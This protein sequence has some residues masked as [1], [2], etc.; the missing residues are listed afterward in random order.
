M[1]KG[2]DQN[3]IAPFQTADFSMK[4][5]IL[6]RK[7]R[8]IDA[9]LFTAIPVIGMLLSIYHN[10][11]THIDLYSVFMYIVPVFVLALHVF[12][13][14]DWAD[15]TRDRNDKL[16]KPHPFYSPGISKKVIIILVMVTGLVSMIWLLYFSIQSFV[17]GLFL[18]LFSLFYSTSGFYFHGKGLP[19]VATLLHIT[20][21]MLAYM[22]GY[23][24]YGE[25]QTGAIL[26][27]LMFGIFLSA[28]HLF[29]EIQDVEGDRK[30][31]IRT[32]ANSTGKKAAAWLGLSLLLCGHALLQYLVY[33]GVFPAVSVF[34]WMAFGLVAAFILLSIQKAL[35]NS[36]VKLL[37]CRYRIVYAVFGLYMVI[38]IF[39]QL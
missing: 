39:V 3:T 18:I 34:N 13:L 21:G 25:I 17:I 2:L 36:S 4:V 15:F 31:Q 37:R 7:S 22:L 8:L 20:G 26:T 6:L 28:G 16:K 9:A 11:F 27:G 30:N 33:S 12:F 1:E 38:K 5:T 23:I 29:Q 14:N 19:G 10:H 32:V 24:Y 35:D